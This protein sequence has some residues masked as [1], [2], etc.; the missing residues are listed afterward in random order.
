MYTALLFA[1]VLIGFG[2]VLFGIGLGAALARRAIGRPP[3][4]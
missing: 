1:V 3:R 2:Y 4:G